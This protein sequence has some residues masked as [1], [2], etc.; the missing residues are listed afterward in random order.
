MAPCGDGSSSLRR[1]RQN[2]RQNAALVFFGLC[3][4]WVLPCWAEPAPTALLS[5]LTTGADGQR[6]HAAARL[7]QLGAGDQ[8]AQALLPLL[9]HV[10]PGQRCMAAQLLGMLRS[11]LA[12]APLIQA[13]SDGDWA[14]RRDA[15][16]ALGQIG[17]VTARAALT[18][19]L[20][21]TQSRVRIAAARALGELSGAD[22]P[23]AGALSVEA[24]PEVRLH[25]VAAL[26]PSQS[27]QSLQ[28]LRS[29]LQDPVESVRLAAATFLVRRG[30]AGGTN[31]LTARLASSPSVQVRIE[32][33]QTLAEA[34]GQAQLTARTALAGAL[35]DQNLT[36]GLYAAQG[37]ARL[38]DARGRTHL[39]QVVASTAPPPIRAQAL[40][41][42]EGID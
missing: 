7:F 16:E 39:Q 40:T 28:A 35:S 9:S 32:T 3:V 26:G 5:Q 1:A 33:A 37:L 8:G 13:L 41:M 23:L 10:D 20:Q 34:T 38:G 18:P 31:L 29:A 12:V 17:S 6:F 2:N 30:D 11:Q 22:G 42:L 21:D 24:D 27:S 14:V 15:A 25:L 19:L 36:V 4:L